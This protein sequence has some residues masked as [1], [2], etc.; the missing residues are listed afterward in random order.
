MSA[1]VSITNARAATH[2]LPLFSVSESALAALA[3]TL[4]ESKRS[5]GCTLYY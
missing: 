4:A 3:A 1:E 5:E 2:T